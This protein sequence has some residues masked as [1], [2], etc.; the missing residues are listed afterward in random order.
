MTFRGIGQTNTTAN[1]DSYTLA[2]SNAP[3][4]N[5]LCIVAVISSKASAP[6]TPTLAGYGM[7]W[8]M[9]AETNFNTLGSPKSKLTLFRSMTNDNPTSDAL[10]ASFGANQTGC[11]M[12]AVQFSGVDTS[13]TLGSNAIVQFAVNGADATANANVT[14]AALGGGGFNSVIAFLGKD[15]VAFSGTPEDGWTEDWDAGANPPSNAGYCMYNFFTT[16]NTV[17]V[18]NTAADWA[19]M[20][21]EIKGDPNSDASGTNVIGAWIDSDGWTLKV[22]IGGDTTTS[23][24]TNLQYYP[25]FLTSAP[26]NW[27]ALTSTQTCALTVTSSGWKDGSQRTIERTIYPTKI[28]RWPWPLGNTNR[29]HIT[30]ATGTNVIVDIALNDYIYAGETISMTAIAGWIANTNTLIDVAAVTSLTVTNDSVTTFADSSEPTMNWAHPGQQR[31]TNSTEYVY[32]KGGHW[33]GIDRVKVYAMDE[34]SNTQEV[35]ASHIRAKPGFGP[36]RGY[37]VA[38]ISTSTFTNFA[39]IRCDYVVYPMIGTNVFDTRWDRWTG[40]TPLPS[41]QTNFLDRFNSFT[42]FGIVALGGGATPVIT[43]GPPENVDPVHYFGSFNAL[44]NAL[45][46]T[47]FHRYGIAESIGVALGRN[48]VTNW[49]GGSLSVSNTARSWSRLKNYPG[50]VLTLTNRTGSQDISDCVKFEGD[51]ANGGGLVLQFG[52]GVGSPISGVARLW[53]DNITVDS[54]ST[55]IFATCSHI[56]MTDVTVSRCGQSITTISAQNTS[57]AI[58]RDVD[59]SGVNGNTWFRTG[60]GITRRGAGN[61]SFKIIDT[62]ANHGAPFSA[63]TI[64]TDSE[65]LQLGGNTI[66][67]FGNTAAVDPATYDV[68]HGFWSENVIIESTNNYV[69]MSLWPMS[70]VTNV[71]IRNWTIQGAR[72]QMIYNSDTNKFRITTRFYNNVFPVPGWAGDLSPQQNPWLTNSANILYQVGCSGNI[73]H[74]PD[75]SP[76]HNWPDFN[77]VFNIIPNVSGTK[78][79]TNF[80]RFQNN[81]GYLGA[82]TTG[83]GDYRLLNNNYLFGISREVG[84]LQVHQPDLGYDIE[85][86]LRSVIDPPGAHV[87]GNVRKGGLF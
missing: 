85:G 13:G 52:T 30:E 33:S 3:I 2:T 29:I 81:Q 12:R 50:D 34:S 79:P 7:T 57:F 84:A 8:Y 56:S 83:L 23:I 6:N 22:V 28:R 58:G 43:N 4:A 86:K 40:P 36:A 78:F 66:L 53:L 74:Y 44:W 73:Y 47:N 63:H 51:T 49:S 59:V 82:F 35:W 80:V 45:A 72:N 17:I 31:W 19:A 26:T 87:S 25:G 1:V 68:L 39:R 71:V 55:Q 54:P 70:H 67:Q 9:I 24:G 77:G 21:V 62:Q 15:T 60:I 37:W 65:F 42:N 41:S 14:L 76:A 11:S 69:S 16:D 38:A 5:A 32:L 27:N 18:T 64:L 48:G 20:A 75:G 61:T 46:A 10:V